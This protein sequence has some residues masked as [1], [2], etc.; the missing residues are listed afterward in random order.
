MQSALSGANA[1]SGTVRFTILTLNVWFEECNNSLRMAHIADNIGKLRPHFVGLQE[2]TTQLLA[3][4]HPLLLHH[5]YVRVGNLSGRPYGELVYARTEVV[6]IV[7]RQEIQFQVQ[8]GGPGSNMCRQLTLVRVTIQGQP[9]VFATA[10]LESLKESKALRL[11]QLAFTFRALD[12][13]NQAWV[14]AGDT[15]ISKSDGDL[16]RSGMIP[17]SVG[18][19]WEAM[20][21][22][23]A[24]AGTWDTT[25]NSHLRRSCSF[26]AL[27]RFDRCYFDQRKLRVESYQLVCQDHI[28]GTTMHVSDHFGVMVQLAFREDV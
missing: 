10:H 5:G 15:N 25:T 12:R 13:M 9:L 19:A 6:T 18:D 28:P 1:L 24:L 22:D 26:R 20:G 27:C 23:P 2:V 3:L 16:H 4:L 21:A 11:A 7:E 8:F 14:F 17:A